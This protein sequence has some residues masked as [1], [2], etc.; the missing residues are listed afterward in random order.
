MIR[1][2]LTTGL[3]FFGLITATA[4]LTLNS[5]N[6]NPQIGDTMTLART[7][8]VSPGNSGANVTWD[9]TNIIISTSSHV[10]FVNPSTT[11]H[12]ANHPTSNLA[13]DYGTGDYEYYI[14][15]SS[16]LERI[17][18]YASSVNIPYS[19]GQSIVEF[20]LS[21][22]GSYNDSFAATFTS[23]V[24]FNRAGTVQGTADAYGTLILP[25]GTIINAL[26]VKYEENYQD[27][28]NPGT[29]PQT[30][31]YTSEIYIWYAPGYSFPVFSLTTF[32]SSQGTSAS[33]GT[34]Q[35]I[36]GPNTAI[37]EYGKGANNMSLYPNPYKA[38][39][40]I[41]FDL[42][43]KGEVDILLTDVTGKLIHQWRFNE[44]TI[45]E[46]NIPL[47]EVSLK[48]GIYLVCLKQENFV[49]TERLVVP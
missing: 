18:A 11:P 36:P 48:K 34:Y 5:S 16:S 33:Y 6:A 30:I 47:S 13:L 29:G 38:G 8:Y 41:K 21:Y 40:A 35:V 10:E 23:G 7:N 49:T 14:T 32:T 37:I 20:P 12:G 46:Y 1:I 3:L 9:F 45:G 19:N 25:S 26:R 24:P 28:Y 31:T 42:A 2:I 44:L 39:T 43:S 27:T 15:S 4:Q 17:G 22:Q